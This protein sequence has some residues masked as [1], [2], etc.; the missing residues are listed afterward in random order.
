MD[1]FTDYDSTIDW[2]LAYKFNNVILT[3]VKT[4]HHDIDSNHIFDSYIY[5][6]IK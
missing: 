2:L 3:F 6:M 1:L 4:F 5:E